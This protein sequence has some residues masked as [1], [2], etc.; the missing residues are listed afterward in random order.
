MC[1]NGD[2]SLVTYWVLFLDHVTLYFFK[3]VIL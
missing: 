3:E 2:I 1:S